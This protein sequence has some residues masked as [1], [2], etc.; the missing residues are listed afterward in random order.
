MAGQAYREYHRVCE[1]EER[2]KEHELECAINDAK[3]FLMKQGFL[4]LPYAAAA[5]QEY[6]N[7]NN[8]ID[9]KLTT[10]DLPF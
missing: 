7:A 10:D 1:E 3:T 9:D 6:N 5:I 8:P 2:Q 4:V